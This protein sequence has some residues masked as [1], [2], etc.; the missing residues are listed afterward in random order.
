MLK[1]QQMSLKNSEIDCEN[2]T[3]KDINLRIKKEICYK[4]L[5]KLTDAKLFEK[6]KAENCC[7][8]YKQ[9]YT[10]PDN[11]IDLSGYF[12]LKEYILIELIR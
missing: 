9:I 8:I 12:Y 10:Y 1:F 6:Y 2:L 7:T 4:T 11:L 5:E 3:V